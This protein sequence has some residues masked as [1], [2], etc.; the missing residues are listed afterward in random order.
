MTLMSVN[1][2][3]PP[4]FVV[5]F[6]LPIGPY[7]IHLPKSITLNEVKRIPFHNTSVSP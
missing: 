5:C 2:N 4:L 3:F 7:L 1:I 6:L